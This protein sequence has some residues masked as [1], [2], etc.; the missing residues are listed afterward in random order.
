MQQS[1]T[2]VITREE[3]SAGPQA[4]W[5]AAGFLLAGFG[6]VLLG[7]ILPSLAHNWHLTD[8]QSGLLLLAKFLGAF[9]GGISVPRR[10]RY[11]ILSGTLLSC[12][13]FGTFGL[14]TGLVT[15]ALTLFVAGVGLG[16]IIASTNIL[17]G[18][19]YREHTGSTLSSL[20]FFFSLGAVL[21]GLI[22]AI[23]LPRYHLTAPLVAFAGLFLATGLGGLINTTPPEP[24]ATSEPE[25]AT[26]SL[27]HAVFIQFA[28]FLFLYGGLETCLTGWLTTFTLRFSDM[29]LLGGQSPLVLLWAALTAGRL[30]ASAALRWMSES[31]VQRLGLACSAA[32]IATLAVAHH[33]PSMSLICVLLGLSLAP[34]FPTTFALLIKHGPPA[35]VA[36]FILAVSGLGAA[37]FPWLMG[38]ISTRSGSLRIA[39]TVPLLLALAMLALTFTPANRP[40]SKA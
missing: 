26:Y 7:P 37:L 8:E 5:L 36:G 20:N 3:A 1:E 40:R 14:S 19:R 27:S 11:G 28:L 15:G 32:L 2:S 38:L 35:R 6:T 24:T 25:A 39:M 17:A 13:G 30:I 31:T 16:Q 29:H 4:P 18:R 33:G 21:T 12:L 23:V 9:C 22:A 34:F 10:L